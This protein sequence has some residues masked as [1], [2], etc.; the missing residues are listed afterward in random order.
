[1]AT[2]MEVD[3]H[4]NSRSPSPAQPPPTPAA[5]GPRAS[6]LQKLYNDAINHVVKTI[7]YSNFSACFPTPS[8]AVPASVKL[9]HEQ[10]TEKLGES[11]RKEF[12]SI[13]A[14]RNVIPSLNELDRLIEDAKRRKARAAEDNNGHVPVPPHTLPAKQLYISHLAPTLGE[15]D[16]QMK[17]RQE[18]LATENQE[19]MGRVMQQ[20]KDIKSLIDGLENVVKD[21]NGSVEALQPEDMQALRE[22]NREVDES[23]R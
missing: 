22:K 13:L 16:R 2:E 11:M 6:A 10:F 12:D 20:R 21:L 14:E 23:M 9:L 7:S 5:P 3:Q 19:I 4:Q 17:E 8:Q 18:L 15:Y 1:M